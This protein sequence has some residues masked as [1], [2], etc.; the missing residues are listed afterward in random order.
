MPK[1]GEE[2]SVDFYPKSR[3]C[4]CEI[5]LRLFPQGC[6]VF[7]SL[8]LLQTEGVFFSLQIISCFYMSL[9]D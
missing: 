7:K 3:D 9:F 1:R 8:V 5:S 4:G 2:K 6:A